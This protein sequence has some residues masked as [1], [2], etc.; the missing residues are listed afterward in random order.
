MSKVWLLQIIIASMPCLSR[1]VT[2]TSA[3]SLI[4]W[5][6]QILFTLHQYF[7]SV[8]CSYFSEP[9]YYIRMDTISVSVLYYRVSVINYFMKVNVFRYK[10]L[11]STKTT[12][13][14]DNAVG[15]NYLASWWIVQQTTER[16]ISKY[17]IIS[18]EG[19]YGGVFQY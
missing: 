14:N 12:A 3:Y 15:R 13:V 5:I 19:I 7:C 11:I 10:Y 6:T 9:V 1:S 8:F 18:C 17:G 16:N 2:S 4:I